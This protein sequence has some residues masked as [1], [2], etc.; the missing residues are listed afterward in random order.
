MNPSN[1]IN[2]GDTVRHNFS[3]KNIG[4]VIAR[5]DSREG[6]YTHHVKWESGS[7]DWYKPNVLILVSNPIMPEQES[8]RERIEKLDKVEL[9]IL[10]FWLDSDS[11]Y[12]Y[13]YKTFEKYTGND[14]KS[15]EVAMKSLREKEMVYYAKG[16]MNEDG[17]VAGSGH[18][19]KW[20]VYKAI[21]DMFEAEIEENET[22][23]NLIY[24]IK[25][26][27]DIDASKKKIR[28]L[29]EQ[30]RERAVKQYHN[31]ITANETKVW[32]TKEDFDNRIAK[33]VMEAKLQEQRFLSGAIDRGENI[34][35]W[36]RKRKS[37]L[38]EGNEN[39]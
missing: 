27:N 25:Y 33:A 35:D 2:Q 36:N 20:E 16:L 8:L 22:I 29:I 1:P 6:G 17:E 3:T 39:A 9:S 15:L 30:D 31:E 37:E 14:R 12:C 34:I 24:S 10:K 4:T 13:S 32:I 11:D 38:T 7:E 21:T 26:S 23:E 18:G 19:I 5:D 28:D